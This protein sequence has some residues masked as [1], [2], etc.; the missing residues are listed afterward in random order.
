[1]RRGHDSRAFV[2]EQSGAALAANLKSKSGGNKMLGKGRGCV[3]FRPLRASA[4]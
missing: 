3:P 4:Y 1:V 2:F